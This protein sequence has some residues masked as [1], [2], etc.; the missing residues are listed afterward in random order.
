MGSKQKHLAFVQ[1]TAG[2]DNGLYLKAT[3]NKTLAYS[4]A[5]Q[6]EALALSGHPNLKL[7]N[8]RWST[9]AQN[10]LSKFE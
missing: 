5:L 4:L 7:S 1:Y 3:R 9:P 6:N 2:Y 10:F 8:R